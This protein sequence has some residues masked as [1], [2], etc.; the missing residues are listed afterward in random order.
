MRK[1]ITTILLLVGFS[2]TGAYS[3]GKRGAKGQPQQAKPSSAYMEDQIAR[4]KAILNFKTVFVEGGSFTMGCTD[5]QGE[6]CFKPEKPA[7]P[8]FVRSFAICKK[9]VTQRQWL[10]VMGKNPSDVRDEKMPVTN[11]SWED[12]QKFIAKLN[13]FLGTSYRLPTEAEW[14]FAARGGIYSNGY[15]YSGSNELSEVGWYK[16]NSGELRPNGF[17]KYNELGLF[18]MSGTIWEW[19][20]DWYGPYPTDTE[21]EQLNPEGASEGTERVVRGGYFE[22][23]DRFC[24]V[25]CRNKSEP[26]YSSSIIGLRLVTDYTD[27][28]EKP[29]VEE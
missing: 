10:E 25:S 22:G 7:H 4:K 15:K 28:A 3:A 18:D 24:R 16:E 5:E 9:C 8:V 23:P 20:S 14:E 21:T 12:A 26:T 2:L 27:N 6:D 19:C 17:K 1:K 29:N 13:N 11:I